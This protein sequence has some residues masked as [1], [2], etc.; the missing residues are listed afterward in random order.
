MFLT[1]KISIKDITPTIWRRM[2]V[3]DQLT[4]QQLHH[5]IQVAFNWS[6]THLYE[7]L[8]DDY[9][10]GA[11]LEFEGAGDNE[12]NV[13]ET[14]LKEFPLEEAEKMAYIYDFGDYWQHEILIEKMADLGPEVPLCLAG[15]RNAP[16]EDSMGVHGYQVLMKGQQDGTLDS[17]QRDWL[18]D[19]DAEAFDLDETNDILSDPDVMN[20]DYF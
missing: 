17:D 18:G 1:L 7:F 12:L 20:P 5:L 14:T 16:P 8:I 19:Y 4:L 6:G 10:I 13:S 9:Q 15:E 2:V 3:S 11:D